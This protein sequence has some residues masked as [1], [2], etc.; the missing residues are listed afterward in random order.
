MLQALQAQP[1]YAKCT[2]CM[3]TLR[4]WQN[5]I[6]SHLDSL[7]HLTKA[8]GPMLQFVRPLH[9]SNKRTAAEVAATPKEEILVR[10]LNHVAVAMEGIFF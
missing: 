3:V 5:D 1:G 6:Q 9:L 2:W 4:G 10:L 8:K 7:K